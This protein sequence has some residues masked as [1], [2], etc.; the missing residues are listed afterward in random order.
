VSMYL[1]SPALVGDRLFGLS[2]SQKGRFF[3]LDVRSGKT[4]WQSGGRQ[5]ENAALVGAG[6]VLLWLTTEA[7]LIVA[8]Q[9]AEAFTP[10]ATYTVAEIPTWAHPALAGRHLL[11]KDRETLTL[12][13]LP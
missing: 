7:E 3:C 5:G 8:A 6:G 4:L 12:W 2:N 9:E 10:L 11:V 13:R 1:S